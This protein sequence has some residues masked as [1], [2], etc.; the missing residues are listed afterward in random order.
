MT[1]EFL[2]CISLVKR[3][4]DQIMQPVCSQYGITRMELDILLFLHNNPEYTTATG[5]IKK[6]RL[7]KSHV[8]SSIKILEEQHFLERYYQEGNEKTI[9][10]KVTPAASEIIKSGIQ[11]QADFYH[12]LFA[13]FSREQ[14]LTMEHNL[15]KMTD[16]VQT[17]LTGGNKYDL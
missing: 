7:T 13:G 6:R 4:Y 5:I 8:S 16:N 2:T 3:L 14:V 17:A 1:T 15:Q 12:T 9:H 10:L 11:A